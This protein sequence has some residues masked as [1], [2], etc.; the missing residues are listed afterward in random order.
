MRCETLHNGIRCERTDTHLYT[1][2]CIHE[3]VRQA[4]LCPRHLDVT[5][6]RRNLCQACNRHETAPHKCPITAQEAA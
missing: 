2:G 3:H 5:E 4:W 6:Q 1:V